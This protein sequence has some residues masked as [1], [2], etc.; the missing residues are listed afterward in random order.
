MTQERTP[1]R[2]QDLLSEVAA[3][4]KLFTCLKQTSGYA[5]VLL[6]DA[7]L[8]IADRKTFEFLNRHQLDAEK[9]VPA[10]WTTS[11]MDYQAF[12]ASVDTDRAWDDGPWVADE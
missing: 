12:C 2:S 11:G 8:Y 10:H 9:N 6:E 7:A 4:G 3:I 1:S 5:A